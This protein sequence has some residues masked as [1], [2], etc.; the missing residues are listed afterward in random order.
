MTDQT[1]LYNLLA[2][3][4]SYPAP[5]YPMAVRK[6]QGLLRTAFP[7]DS[8]IL[9][10]FASQVESSSLE[11]LEELF[12]RTFDLNPVCCLEVG[13]Q[14]YGE[15]Y[16]RGS[17]MVKMR[18]QLRSLGIAE[19]IELPDH[20]SNL[21]PLLA[22][23]EPAEAGP[24]CASYILPALRKM[25]QGITGKDNPYEEVLDVV[26]RLIERQAAPYAQIASDAQTAPYAQT[27]QGLIQIERKEEVIHD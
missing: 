13:W 3:L 12:T 26:A 21:L 19:S 24:L 10:R 5:E 7:E 16:N 27:I 2:R 14:L 18:Q 9:H 25:Q 8:Q 4:L 6:C 15:D 11:E 23:L 17:F 20:L 1:Q 22:R